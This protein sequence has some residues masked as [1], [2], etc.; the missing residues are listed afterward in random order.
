MSNNYNSIIVEVLER[1]VA[2]L[3]MTED[4]LNKTLTEL[5]VDS[6]D[7]ML[8]LMDIQEKTGI[9]IPEEKADYLDTPEKIF[10]FLV[11]QE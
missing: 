7:V 5:G 6:L 3:S 8:I 9:M 4:K 1:N 2:G 11:S 10:E